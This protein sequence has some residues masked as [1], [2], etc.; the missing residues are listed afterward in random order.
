MQDFRANEANTVSIQGQETRPI[1]GAY[2]GM[3][4]HKDTIAVAAALAGREAPAYCGEI[5]NRPSEI[6]KLAAKLAQAHGGELILFCYE[7]GPCGYE[8]YRQLTALG[9]DCEV[10][11]PSRIPKAPGERIKTDRRDA[12]KLARLSR[13]GELTGVWVP[14][15]EQEAMRD[16]VRARADFKNAERKTRQQLGAFLLRHGRHWSRSRWTLAH[17]AWL[18]GLRFERDWQEWAFREYLDAVRAASDRV[19]ALTKQL[20]DALPSWSMAP[21]VRSLVALRGVDRI[22]AMTLLSELGDVS[23]FDSP[24]QLMAYV[25]LVP[26]EHS[27][28][29]RRHQGGITRTGNGHVRRTLVESAWSYRF[30]A[31][32][33]AH[34]ERKAA[35]ASDEAKE[36][37]WK[38]QRRLC[39]RYRH[40]LQAGK[41]SKQAN[42]AVARELSGFVWDI[43]CREMARIPPAPRP[44][45]GSSRSDD[46]VDIG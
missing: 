37:A 34:L 3:D 17:Y 42:V 13:S 26:S 32:R 4:V 9:F 25:G 24:W 19:A 29:A 2:V 10:V 38:A 7:A 15:E 6:G 30:P 16:L 41:N 23:R 18:D 14:D 46:A 20:D 33:T 31:R 1:Y 43:V 45:T 44:A 27:S 8:V 21:V 22:T 28:G 36:I 35:A 39:G 40:L 5:A 11:A 12:G